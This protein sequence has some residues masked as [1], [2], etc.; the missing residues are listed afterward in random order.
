MTFKV[1]PFK[2]HS[3]LL[4]LWGSECCNS[5]TEPRKLKKIQWNDLEMFKLCHLHLSG[6]KLHFKMQSL[7]FVITYRFQNTT[8]D[9][10]FP[11][12]E[13]NSLSTKNL[14]NWEGAS[15]NRFFKDI[16][17]SNYFISSLCEQEDRMKH[18]TF[19]TVLV[20]LSFVHTAFQ[21][22]GESIF[23]YPLQKWMWKW[24]SLLSCWFLRIFKIFTQL[25]NSAFHICPN[26]CPQKFPKDRYR[27]VDLLLKR[28][29]YSKWGKAGNQKERVTYVNKDCLLG[30]TYLLIMFATI[31]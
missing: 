12:L 21:T 6:W 17:C 27:H 15:T 18:L 31:K 26:F 2:V 22:L 7:N 19:S 28:G 16:Y 29:E 1:H 13:P 4:R 25:Y 14:Q 3:L 30:T 24:A 10:I 11:Y 5:S 23:S 20:F 9:R 8:C